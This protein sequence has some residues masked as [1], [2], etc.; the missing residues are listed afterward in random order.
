ME[1]NPTLDTLALYIHDMAVAK[2]F[3]QPM[4]RMSHEDNF[5]FY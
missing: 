3:W 2:G 4:T 5:V 1:E